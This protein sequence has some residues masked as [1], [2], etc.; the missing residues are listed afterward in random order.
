[1]LVEGIYPDGTRGGYTLKLDRCKI[2][3]GLCFKALER[4]AR[5]VGHEPIKWDDE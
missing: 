1:M 3:I 5:V 4:V 2:S